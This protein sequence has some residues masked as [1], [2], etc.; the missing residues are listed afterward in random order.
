MTNNK[1]AFIA[2]VVVAVLAVAVAV[3]AFWKISQET[4]AEAELD[5]DKNAFYIPSEEIKDEMMDNAGVLIERSYTIL[6]LYYIRG[7]PHEEEP[8][9]NLP[10]D[11]I[12][13]AVS[14]DYA[15]LEELEALVD[16][17]FIASV[18]ATI[19]NN[20]NGNGRVYHDKN[21][22][23]GI[24]ADFVPETDYEVSWAQA[25]YVLTPISDTECEVKVTVHV[26]ESPVTETVNMSKLNGVWLL[27][28]LIY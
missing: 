27:D 23:L 22:R 1:P 3:F 18:A 7:L 12:Y 6:K 28:H 5:Q 14:D 19:K 2:T 17:T 26:G 11:G 4:Q 15:T 24:S 20:P 16:S 25:S 13:Y 9:G 10:E 8:Y 21:G